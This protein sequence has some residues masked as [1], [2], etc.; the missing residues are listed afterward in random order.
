[1]QNKNTHDLI[2]Q[3]K[4]KKKTGALPASGEKEVYK[5]CGIIPSTGKFCEFFLSAPKACRLQIFI[6]L[7]VSASENGGIYEGVHSNATTKLN[8]K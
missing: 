5:R 2:L 6:I 8:I 3:K 1:M 7:H 4:Q